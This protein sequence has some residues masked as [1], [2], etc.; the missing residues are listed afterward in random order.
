M[1]SSYRQRGTK[2]GGVQLL[3]AEAEE[4]VTLTPTLNRRQISVNTR[5]HD[6]AVRVRLFPGR[7]F[8]DLR[9]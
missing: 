1:L 6:Y 8:Q 5:R 7:C 4:L 2:C 9:P 3:G